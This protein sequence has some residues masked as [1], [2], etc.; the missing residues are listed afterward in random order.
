MSEYWRWS[1]IVPE[2]KTCTNT[3]RQ[4]YAAQQN[5]NDTAVTWPHLQIFRIQ[6]LYDLDLAT[7]QKPVR[8]ELTAMLAVD[9]KYNCQKS[10]WNIASSSNLHRANYHVYLLIVLHCHIIIYTGR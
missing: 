3:N 4:L 2:N 8:G 1:F 9:L 7:S 5:S 10:D 6:E